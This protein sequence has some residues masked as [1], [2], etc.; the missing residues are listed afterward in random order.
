MEVNR[1]LS[2]KSRCSHYT[3]KSTHPGRTLPGH[4]TPPHLVFLS[5][6]SLPGFLHKLF[7]RLAAHRCLATSQP[8]E[9]ANLAPLL[10][11]RHA[12]TPHDG[13]RV[14][15]SPDARR[16]L[17]VEGRQRLEL[18]VREKPEVQQRRRESGVHVSGRELDEGRE[19][20][21]HLPYFLSEG[22]VLGGAP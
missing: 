20:Q 12:R 10:L 17:V 6:P 13:A 9:F 16:A 3:P 21:R 19:G 18:V 2:V 1:Y 7:F 15:T 22:H 5:P 11:E 8:D 14:V 4:F